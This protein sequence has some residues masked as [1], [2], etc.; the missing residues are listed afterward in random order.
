MDFESLSKRSWTDV[1]LQMYK[2]RTSFL[3]F[4]IG[5]IRVRSSRT[6]DSAH[7]QVLVLCRVSEN[8]LD[9]T[10][11]QGNMDGILPF[12]SQSLASNIYSSWELQLLS[13]LNTH[14]QSMRETVWGAGRTHTSTV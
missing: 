11:R 2:V 14:Y 7:A 9:Q 1:L 3:T 4:S 8:S 12:G 10:V 5:N 13:W 6:Q